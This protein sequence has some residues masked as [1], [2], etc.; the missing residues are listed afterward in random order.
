MASRTFPDSCVIRY[1]PANEGGPSRSKSQW[2][3]LTF[4]G[5]ALG[6]ATAHQPNV[7]HIVP[8]GHAH[9]TAPLAC[10]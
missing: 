8:A 5:T 10:L 9:A 4:S 1:R 7:C 2:K 3:I 6:P